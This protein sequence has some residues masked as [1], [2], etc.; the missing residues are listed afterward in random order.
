MRI[1]D[2]TKC[3][4]ARPHSWKAAKAETHV[5][6]GPLLVLEVYDHLGSCEECQVDG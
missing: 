4:C 2:I 1:M 6:T 5:S 3:G